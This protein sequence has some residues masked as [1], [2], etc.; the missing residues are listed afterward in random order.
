[1]ETGRACQGRERTGNHPALQALGLGDS[2]DKRSNDKDKRVL[3]GE[4]MIIENR[5][6]GQRARVT[7]W[8]FFWINRATGKQIDHAFMYELL[9]GDGEG[10]RLVESSDS[11]WKHWRKW[12]R[13]G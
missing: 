9:D 3:C 4:D 2:A 11:L 5:E 12:S 7:H 6:T 1:M 13:D 8:D 10:M